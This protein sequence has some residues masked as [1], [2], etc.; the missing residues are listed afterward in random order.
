MKKL[1]LKKAVVC[2][3]NTVRQTNFKG[4]LDADTGLFISLMGGDFSCTCPSLVSTC[5]DKSCNDKCP[6]VPAT[7]KQSM[8]ITIESEFCG[9]IRTGMS[10]CAYCGK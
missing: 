6:G 7:D 5:Y 1:K 8:C 4:G 9:T 3:L 10:D 2:R